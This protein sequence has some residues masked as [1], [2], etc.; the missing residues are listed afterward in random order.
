MKVSGGGIEKIIS[1]QQELNKLCAE[2]NY[3]MLNFYIE[4]IREKIYVGVSLDMYAKFPEQLCK[5]FK[6]A[7]HEHFDEEWT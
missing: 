4:N 6:S 1:T 5:F 3:G 7:T 2:S